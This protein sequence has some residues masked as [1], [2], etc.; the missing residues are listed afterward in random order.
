MAPELESGVRSEK[1]YRGFESCHF[2]QA[3]R[4]PLRESTMSII[5][6]HIPFVNSQLGF[7]ERAYN[8]FAG[9]KSPNEHR[10]KAHGAIA[11]AFKLLISDLVKADQQLDAAD[12]QKRKQLSGP[13]QLS[14]RLEEIEGLP[15]ELVSELSSA[16]ATDKIEVAVLALLD[17]APGSITSMDRLLVGI[18]RRTGDVLKRAQL[19]S[20]LYR[21][22]QRGL[23]FG[24][25]GKKGVYASRELTQE[26]VDQAFAQSS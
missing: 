4:Q 5:A 18:Y 19:T 11:N 16:T 25:P 14:L 15:A 26:E 1:P 6:E 22:A 9:G 17:E 8:K 23:I 3:L 12:E 21:M 10:A 2:H 13:I 7:H 20:K 24:V